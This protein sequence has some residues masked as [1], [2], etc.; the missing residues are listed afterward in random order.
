MN[1]GEIWKLVNGYTNYFIS[2]FGRVKNGN[3]M[4]IRERFNKSGYLRV[5]LYKDGQR[6][7][8]LIHRLMAD[9]FIENKENKPVV[10]HINRVRSD[11]SL[12][13]LRWASYRENAQNSIRVLNKLNKNKL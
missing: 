8:M 2:N 13:N 5:D 3:D 4:I 12:N 10:D 9:A 11:N 1:K 7:T 6:R